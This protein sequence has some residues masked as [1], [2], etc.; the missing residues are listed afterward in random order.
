MSEITT[1]SIRGYQLLGLIGEGAYGAVYRAHQQAVDRQVAVKIIQPEFANRPD[2]IRRFEAEAQ[3]VAQLEHLHIVPLYDY[4]RDPQG[5]YLVMRL[6]KGGSLAQSLERGEAWS[7]EQVAHLLEQVAS[8]LDAAHHKGIVHRDLKPAN[9]LLDEDGNAFLSDFGIAKQLSDDQSATASDVITGT[10]AYLTP[11]QIQSQP[12]SPQTDIYALGVLLF[13]LL[14]G[15]HPFPDASSGELVAKHL[16]EPL[17]YVRQNQPDLPA[18][19]DGVIQ[20]A[21]AKNPADRYPD[22]ASLAADFRQALQL[23]VESAAIPESE[24][25]NP[26]KGL[27]AFQEADSEDFFGRE[28]LTGQLLAHLVSPDE[29]GRFL[30]VVG[31]SGSG[32][33]SVV[34]AGLLPALRK[35]ALPGSD[36]WFM[37][38]MH[39][40]SQPFKQMELALLAITSDYSLDLAG[41]LSQGLLEAVQAVLP[42][43]QDT[44]LLV[45]DQFEELFVSVQDEDLRERFLAN[46]LEAVSDPHSQLRLVL[47]LRADFY[48]RPL[49]Y[50]QFGKLVEEHTAVVLP[51]TP[52]ELQLA[53]RKPAERVSAVLEKGLVEEITAEVEDQPGSLPLLQYALTELFERREGRMLTLQAYQSIGGVLGALG[54]RAEGVYQDLKAEDK[55][56][57]RQ[58]F[59]RLVTLGEG[60]ED[61]R[62]RVPQAELEALASPARVRSVL[63]AFGAARLLS[64]DRDPVT[65]GPTVEV[66]HEALLREWVRL[67]GW[68]DESRADIRM[69][70]LL[71]RATRDWLQGDQEPSFLLRGSRLAQFQEWAGE[72]SLALTPDEQRFLEASLE[73]QARRREQ[74]AT[75]ERRSRNFLRALVAVFAVAALV[76]IGLTIFAFNQQG[77]AQDNAATAIAE[78][79]ARA[80]QQ[81]IAENEANARA[82][83][84]TIAES[85]AIARGEA[86]EQ[87]L[88]DRDRAVEAEQEAL[89]QREEAL[90]QAAIGLAS[91][92]ELEL[93]GNARERAVLLALEALE[94]YPYTWQAERA[95]SR[96][97]LNSRLRMLVPY[98]G[99][100]VT[101]NWS[102][103]GSMILI[104]GSVET[105]EFDYENGF[106]RVLD[107]ATGEQL[108]KI[109]EGNPTMASWSPD[110]NF[111]LTLGWGQE[112]VLKFAHLGETLAKIEGLGDKKT[113]ETSLVKIWDIESGLARVTLDTDDLGGWLWPNINGWEPWSPTGDRF[114]TYTVDGLV[115]IFD[116]NTGELLHS[117]SEYEGIIN[118]EFGISISQ[119]LWSPRG[120]LIAISS[121]GD[122]STIVYQ[123]DTGEPLYKIPGDFETKVVSVGSWSP[124]GDRFITRG[125][126]GAK[127]YEAAT[128]RKV[129]DLSIP[130]TNILQALWSPDGSRILIRESGETVT[131]W[132]SE[133]GQQLIEITDMVF[134]LWADWSPTGEY[135]AVGAAD[136]F[137]H[138]WDVIS[139]QEFTK[140]SGTMGHPNR[141]EFSPDSEYIL[142]AGDDNNVNILNLS[143]ASLIVPVPTCGWFSNVAWSPDGEQFAISS[144]CPPDE[145]LRVWDSKSGSQL[146]TL[147]GDAGLTYM[148]AWSPTGDRIATTH[149]GLPGAMIWDAVTGEK[150]STFE[151]HNIGYYINDVDWSPDGSQLATASWD[152]DVILWDSNTGEEMLTFTNHV[153]P[154]NSIDWS[155]DG[156]RIISTSN[157]GEALIWEAATGQVLL[158]LMPEE[159]TASISDSKWTQDGQRVILVS[160]DGYVRIFDAETGKNLSQFS[161]PIAS[162]ISTI[163]L[164]PTEEHLIIGGYEGVAKVYNIAT[165]REMISYNVGG[166]VFP[167]YAPDGTRVLVGTI[168]GDVG[169]M[170][171]FPTWH[172]TLELIAYAK[173]CCLVRELTPEEREQFGLPPK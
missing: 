135:V 73:D 65:R 110:E 140:L 92:S 31:P 95:L 111:V 133:S 89:E 41:L 11:E 99:T 157:D 29:S 36:Q 155:P 17:P 67:R 35:G 64:F 83:Q 146:L 121:I 129:L 172:S 169:K 42:S 18:A 72:T 3:L 106:A 137:V 102:A 125:V 25:Y 84:Q 126:G 165:G 120:D 81:V 163:S 19:L 4:W 164:S 38:E 63:E 22:G 147:S 80:T 57:A 56:L 167:T 55:D 153:Y 45:I 88:Q 112:D 139:G 10:P 28:A 52:E 104:G 168:T 166:V 91:Q 152:T 6:M 62:R 49:M 107:A 108:L 124:S 90:R 27:R 94:D 96:A 26:Y 5:A 8:G 85:E 173:E 15:K 1:P 68:L 98:I 142:V 87:A 97:I 150:L 119:A 21:T 138:V 82:T 154:V 34:K 78:A 40:G 158:P 75:L 66:A 101:T 7:P 24:L 170:Q 48:D 76:A 130:R 145:Q 132:D 54:R 122:D 115:K 43:E 123:V 113:I 71:G 74:Q 47:T 69:Q 149:D 60:A 100:L 148:M 44:L 61:T 70:R 77:I 141:I 136:G 39:P 93:D 58:L 30:A 160:A 143:E 114:L 53:I 127:V 32:K 2:F 23:Q 159:F 171:V 50:P 46:L 103:D 16:Q 12:L 156:S 33:S 134:A 13:E 128:G 162:D 37:L 79:D 109:T 9:I 117:L 161:T 131:V 151:G 118:E 20:R 86:E 59:L 105:G 51:L 116:I 144:N 14:T